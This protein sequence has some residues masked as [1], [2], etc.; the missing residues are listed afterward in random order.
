M[1]KPILK[2][3]EERRLKTS[4]HASDYGKLGIE[5]MLGLKNVEPT[6]PIEWSSTLRMAAGKGV[7]LQMVKVLKANN[8]ISKDF[9]QESAEATE[10]E[11]DGIKIRMRFDALALPNAKMTLNDVIMPDG[12]TIEMTEGEPIEIK[13]LNNKNSFDIQS[14]I[15]NKPRESYV[16]QLAIYCDALGK[17]RGHLFV[18]AIDGLNY[19]WFTC[20]HQGNRIYKCGETIVD[21]NKEYKRW[22]KIAEDVK[23]ISTPWE[24]ALDV[25]TA[26]KKWKEYWFEE[27]YKIPI[28]KIDW[29]KLSTTKIGDARNGRLVIGSENKWKI[30]YSNYKDML[31][32]AQGA[33]LGY[34]PEDLEKIKEVTAGFSSKKKEIKV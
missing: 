19:F 34:S 33:T 16:G 31:V 8:I 4:F 27:L 22:A 17:E 2:Y 10:I 20:E 26:E 32:R 28:D 11:R 12:Q 24:L 1:S 18:S 29:S 14:Y 3:S 6:N 15:D 23:K 9:D 13:T 5:I 21:L 7:E 25:F 30:D